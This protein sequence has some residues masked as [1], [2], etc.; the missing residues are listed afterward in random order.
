MVAH[1][2]PDPFK[3]DSMVQRISPYIPPKT[4]R[5]SKVKEAQVFCENPE[6]G[7]VLD[8]YNKFCKECRTQN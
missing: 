2:C 3:G 5:E 8:P 1:G 7:A 4:K 6:C